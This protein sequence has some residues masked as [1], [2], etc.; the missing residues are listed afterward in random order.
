M[1]RARTSR[2]A[3]RRALRQPALVGDSGTATTVTV[4]AM[5]PLTAVLLFAGVQTVL[6]QHARTIAA[7]RA[8]QIAA[9]VATGN[10][11]PDSARV[12]LD[13][14]LRAERDLR[15]VTVTVNR[16]AQLVTVDV[17][18]EVPGILVGTTTRI[19]V[20]ASAPTEGWQP[21]P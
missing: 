7:D 17:I 5:F 13:G 21:L 3:S 6:W 8:D 12:A 18:A 2:E 9:Q 4:V 10:L 1:T 16:D 20:H 19:R 14:A 11:N 15:P